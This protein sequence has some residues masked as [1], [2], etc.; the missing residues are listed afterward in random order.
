MYA[1][2]A[3]IVIVTRGTVLNPV[4]GDK[5]PA[6]TVAYQ[7]PASIQ[8][9]S[10]QY[11]DQATQTPRTVRK[12]TMRIASTAGILSGDYILDTK[13]NIRFVAQ[14]VTQ[15]LGALFTPDQVVDLTRVN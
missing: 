8:E 6:S 4:T 7:G 3:T 5:M 1:I 14:G 10:H 11:W 15:N 9:D 12:L 2:P 13:R